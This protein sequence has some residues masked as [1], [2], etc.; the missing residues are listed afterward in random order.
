MP[1]KV[2]RLSK[3]AR[4]LN[5]GISFIV[6]L[7]ASKSIYIDSNPNTKLDEETYKVVINEI[8][9][10]KSNAILDQYPVGNKIVGRIIK[11]IEPGTIFILIHHDITAT[12]SVLDISWNLARAEMIYQSYQIGDEVTAFIIDSCEEAKHI[13]LSLKDFSLRPSE[14]KAWKSIKLG[15]ILKG[16]IIE[17]LPNKKIVKLENELFGILKK[18][19][20]YQG[21]EFQVVKKDSE[22]NIISLST[23]T[24]HG[25]REE[26][27]TKEKQLSAEIEVINEDLLSLESFKNSLYADFTD[28]EEI[29]FM[30]HAFETVPELFSKQLFLS[31]NIILNFEFNS[32]A[33]DSF[34]SQIVPSLID[35]IAEDKNDISEAIEQIEKQSFWINLS[36]KKYD[37]KDYFTIYNDSIN[38]YGSID[39]IDS[40]A[41]QFTVFTISSDRKNN[42]AGVGQKY[43][44]KNGSF[45]LKNGIVI[46]PPERTIPTESYQNQYRIYDQLKIKTE[47]FQRIEKLKVETGEII[48][49]EGE[50]LKIFDKFLEYQEDY[51]KSN[52]PEPV[53][54]DNDKLKRTHGSEYI[55][56][57]LP[58]DVYDYLNDEEEYVFLDLRE[59]IKSSKQNKEYEFKKIGTGKAFEKDGLWILSV[60]DSLPLDEVKELFIQKKASVTQ[61]QLQREII[62]DFFDKKLKLD[63][64]ENLLVRP[65]KIKAPLINDVN[66]KNEFLQKTEKDY[67]DNN[68]VK[69]VKKAI[70]NQ[71]IFL[72]QGPPGTGKTTVI[73]EVVEQLVA[74]KKKILVAS[75]THVAVDNVLEKLASS[76]EL[77]LL[78]V[79]P[80]SKISDNLKQYHTSEQIK[81]YKQDFLTFIDVQDEIIKKFI[82]KVEIGE[83]KKYIKESSANYSKTL[84]EKL[85]GDHY[86]LFG[87]LKEERE[88]IDAKSISQVLQKWKADVESGLQ[89]IIAPILFGSVDVVFA[90]C[91][92]IKSHSEFKDSEFKFDTVIIDEAGKANLAES[93][94]AI[95]MAKNIILVGDQMQLP[96]YMDSNLIDPNIEGSFPNS[97]YGKNFSFKDIEHALKTSFFEFLVNRIKGGGFPKENLEKL[98]Y[99]HRMH[100]NIGM[101]V[102][103]SFYDGDVNM[104]EKTHL[105]KIDLPKPFDKEITFI[106]TSSYIDP[107]EK[108]DG[109][110]ATN[111]SEAETIVQNVLPL[112]LKEGVAV[113]QVAIIAPYK[114]Q[115]ALIQNEIESSRNHLMINISVSTLDSFQGMEFDVIIFSFTRSASPYQENKKVGFLD[116]ARRLNVAF[117]RAKKKLILVGNEST[118]TRKSSHFDKFFDYTGLFKNLINLSKT[119]E[120]GRYCEITDF[121]ELCSP[122]E[123]FKEKHPLKSIASG[124]IKSIA[125]YGIF[126]TVDSFDGLVHKSNLSHRVIK[127]INDLFEVDQEI[128]VKV[129]GFND[130]KQKVELGIK[131]LNI[132]SDTDF[133]KRNPINSRTEG[134]IT[135]IAN[136]GFFVNIEGHEG[137]VHKT[138]IPNKMRDQISKHFTPDQ[139]V[140]VKILDYNENLSRISLALNTPSVQ[141][142]IE[143]FKEVKSKYCKNLLITCPVKNVVKSGVFVEIEEG[144][145]GIIH[146]SQ[147][148]PNKRN[149]LKL[150]YPLGKEVSVIVTNYNDGKK[151]IELSES[152]ALLKLKK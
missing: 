61:F 150:N 134:F 130:K 24:E 82:D 74:E 118:L 48:K 137:L 141:K 75:Q 7:L 3:V 145:D 1:S 152:L 111:R 94:V 108:S 62:R 99:Q 121:K 128:K 37:E 51:I 64:V 16:E 93:L 85:S 41:C 4:E 29:N 116:D 60:E 42:I 133:K 98:N 136:Y 13:R 142:E 27:F 21:D 36:T 86:S 17:N 79:G 39:E 115:V 138:N 10:K 15:N 143:A 123:R 20:D 147:L 125:T 149:N 73:S 23:P 120:A 105:N 68:Q 131:Q 30:E 40:E 102:S 146:I 46:S 69:A 96:P 19:D 114:S 35:K 139:K 56:W 117:S 11:K 44:A 132:I 32:R 54:I 6:D 107:Y 76:E 45:L 63:H 129:I 112:L 38:F 50:A 151:I 77:S 113:S 72:I 101:F 31:N 22:K 103:K 83:I 84:L 12:I 65:E 109:Y 70:G 140:M 81:N 124:V 95:S 87:L 52:Q 5:I 78:R 67:P 106:N 92:G 49:S 53:K 33:W 71:N 9:G 59:K 66:F 91:I 8:Q 80:I 90:T 88:V 104:G 89:E 18:N 28:E 25:V 34:Q 55:T 127:N 57:V 119:P 122:Y 126:V 148:D 26:Q 14:T 110:S 97:K 43:A 144:L 47:S 135:N 58:S 2:I 100:P